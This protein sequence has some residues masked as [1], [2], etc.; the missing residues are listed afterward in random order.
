[1]VG[2]FGWTIALIL[3]VVI[4]FMIVPLNHEPKDARWIERKVYSELRKYQKKRGLLQ[5][6]NS[7]ENKP[8]KTEESA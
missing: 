3:H 8:E 2:F 1:M 7:Q 5:N 4:Y 6:G